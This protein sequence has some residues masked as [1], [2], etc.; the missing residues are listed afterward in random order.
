M[1]IFVF[2]LLA[3]C[4]QDAGSGDDMGSGSGS[5]SDSGSAS[6][7]TDSPCPPGETSCLIPQANGLVNSCQCI[8][9]GDPWWACSNCPFSETSDPVT[10]ATAGIGCNITTWEHDCFCTCTASGYW[11]CMKGTV[12]SVCPTAP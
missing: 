12:G 1:R 10:C 9:T 8:T 11:D 2:V 3:A 7:A 6:C 4:T 5:G